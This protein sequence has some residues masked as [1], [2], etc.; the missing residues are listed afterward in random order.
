M[1]H[2]FETVVNGK[3]ILSKTN[4]VIDIMSMS[5]VMH[6]HLIITKNKN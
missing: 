4:S 3:Y 5:T 1:T 2:E 6:D